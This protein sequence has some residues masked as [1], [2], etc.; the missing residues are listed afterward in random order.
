[1]RFQGAE[2]T[3][4]NA[5]SFLVRKALNIAQMDCVLL[6]RREAGERGGEILLQ[7]D[8]RRSCGSRDLATRR[9]L[10][11]FSFASPL[12]RWV[13]AAAGRPKP[14]VSDSVQPGAEGRRALKFRETPIG[15]KECLLREIVGQRQLATRQPAQES[16]QRRLVLADEFS[17]GMPIVVGQDAGDEFCIA[18][19]HS[20]AFEK[21]GDCQRLS[22]EDLRSQSRFGLAV[23]LAALERPIDEER[24]AHQRGNEPEPFHALRDAFLTHHT[25][26]NVQA[27]AHGN[28]DE[29]APPIVTRFSGE[30]GEEL[31]RQRFALDKFRRQRL[32]LFQSPLDRLMSEFVSVRLL[33]R[34]YQG[35]A[36]R[37]DHPGDRDKIVPQD[38]G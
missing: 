17:E 4:Q 30:L 20:R 15:F 16:A 32:T 11:H 13:L 19:I 12:D 9:G 6:V 1:M 25:K 5:G 24:P 3:S 31:G 21:A 14:V 35:D 34:T 36:Q 10:G 18:A 7:V 38:R 37:K 29:A 28:R 8:R 23:L 22:P 26:E 27:D 2:R 33:E